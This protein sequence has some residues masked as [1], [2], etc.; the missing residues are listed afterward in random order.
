MSNGREPELALAEITITELALRY[1]KFAQGYY[2]KD[3]RCTQV[4][5]GI[6]AALKYVREW[7]G[8]EPATE[9]GPIRLKALRDKMVQDGLSRNYI[10]EHCDRLKRMF[11]WAVAEQLIPE[12]TY[13]TLAVV[14]GLR[15]GRTNARETAPVLPVA[16]EI[17]DATVAH[18]PTVLADM[19]RMQRYTAMRPTE[20]CIMRPCDVDRSGEVW[21]YRPESHKTEHHGRERVVLLG[22]KAQEVLLRYLARDPGAYCFQPRD[23]EAKRL[24]EREA[25]RK[26]PLSCG[27]TRGS[28]RKRHP[29]KRAG[30]CYAVATY[31]RAITRAC[32]KAKVERW[33]PNRLR[34][35][36][37]TEARREFG[38]E[39]AQILLG[40]RSADITQVYAERDMLKGIEAAKRI[41]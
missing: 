3:G 15:K 34:H 12:S 6:K 21:Q 39:A 2:V 11:K 14:G 17:V 33:S 9:F 4:V 24:A 41:G 18:L 29:K 35:A 30:K 10:N 16:D 20:V 26:T 23:S 28:N 31:R 38:L 5:P 40:H 7:Y 37:A 13:R 25:A 27:N 36:A 8:K 32:D 19:V 1:L 22:P